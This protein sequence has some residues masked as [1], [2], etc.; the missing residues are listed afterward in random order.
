MGY[1][2]RKGRIAVWESRGRDEMGWVGFGE[3]GRSGSLFDLC[4][5][6]V[7][8]SGFIPVYLDCV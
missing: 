8:P 3:W 6:F 1:L 4:R 7:Y 2:E 5:L